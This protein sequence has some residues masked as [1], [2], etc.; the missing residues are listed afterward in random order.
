MVALAKAARAEIWRPISR[1]GERR[2]KE[3]REG[4]WG[5]K[6]KQ[7]GSGRTPDDD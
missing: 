5:V 2:E 7:G 4:G 3:N 1:A 6:S